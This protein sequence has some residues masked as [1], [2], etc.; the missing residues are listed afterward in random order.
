MS[1]RPITDPGH[2]M[3][4][5]ESLPFCRGNCGKRLSDG[6]LEPRVS[7][8]VVERRAGMCGACTR[9]PKRLNREQ[10]EWAVEFARSLRYTEEYRARRKTLAAAS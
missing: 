10:A 4:F 7:G 8:I 1:A 9:E 3:E 5:I 2:P 6:V